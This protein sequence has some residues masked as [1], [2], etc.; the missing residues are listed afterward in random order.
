MREPA[1][2][3]AVI[4]AELPAQI[5]EHSEIV[6]RVHVQGDHVGE[7]ANA[8]LAGRVRRQ[9]RSTRHHIVQ[10]FDDGE[11]LGVDFTVRPGQRRNKC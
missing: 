5:V 9:K 7:N 6:D 3:R 11:R 4:C 10:K 8:C 1:R 2:D